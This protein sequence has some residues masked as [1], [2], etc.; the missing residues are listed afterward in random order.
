MFWSIGVFQGIERL[1]YGRVMALE[2][3]DESVVSVKI[4]LVRPVFSMHLAMI[5]LR[6]SRVTT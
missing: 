2:L 4:Y 6:S 1:S 3:E 5:C